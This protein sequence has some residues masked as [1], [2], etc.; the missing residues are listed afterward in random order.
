MRSGGMAVRSVRELVRIKKSLSEA[1]DCRSFEATILHAL[2]MLER[3]N[4]N[5]TRTS[6]ALGISVRTMR[7][8]IQV[9]SAWG[10]DVPEYKY[11]PK[12][13]L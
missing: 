7:L 11:T 12:R 1:V 6:K 5:R 9:M 3:N 4:G 10:L 2:I 13:S 8:W